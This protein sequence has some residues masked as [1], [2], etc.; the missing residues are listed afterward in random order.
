M[1]RFIVP[2]IPPLATAVADLKSNMDRFID[3]ILEYYEQIKKF[4]IQYG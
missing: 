2:C 3:P 4:K 1:D